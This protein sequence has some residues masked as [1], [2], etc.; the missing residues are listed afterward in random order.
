MFYDYK[1]LGVA[2]LMV[3]I[4]SNNLKITSETLTEYF[5]VINYN[6]CSIQT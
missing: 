2:F 4:Q 1:P 3:I 6:G 5:L